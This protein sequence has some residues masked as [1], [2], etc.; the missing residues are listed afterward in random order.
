MN[1]PNPARYATVL[2]QSRRVILWV[3]VLVLVALGAAVFWGNIRA[4]KDSSRTT[5]VQSEAA[6]PPPQDDTN[7]P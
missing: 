5:T 4:E 3:L 7:K 6:Q 1:A 2:S